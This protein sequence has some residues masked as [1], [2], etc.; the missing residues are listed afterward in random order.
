[1]STIGLP[2]QVIQEKPVANTARLRKR[3][4]T[5]ELRSNV[6]LTDSISSLEGKIKSILDFAMKI[7]FHRL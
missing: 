2:K 4:S 6:V 5:I 7:P 1:M 3:N